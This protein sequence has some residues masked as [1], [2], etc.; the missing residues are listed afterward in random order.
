MPAGHFFNF[1]S[2]KA[3]VVRVELHVPS[4]IRSPDCPDAAHERREPYRESG[5]HQEHY[6]GPIHHY[7]PC[8]T[9]HQ[10][11]VRFD[12]QDG[13]AVGGC[14][15]YDVVGARPRCEKRGVKSSQEF[16]VAKL[17]GDGSARRLRLL[18]PAWWT[19][20]PPIP[21]HGPPRAIKRMTRPPSRSPRRELL[22][23]SG[24]EPGVNA[25]PLFKEPAARMTE[26]KGR[27]VVITINPT[28]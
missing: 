16:G 18:S 27:F 17:G 26:H 9:D 21:G 6:D 2:R 7:E 20:P 15:G 13:S 5:E 8:G 4:F 11:G 12:H 25:S 10:N 1:F 24:S 23:D 3:L 22:A 19:G 14:T 28:S